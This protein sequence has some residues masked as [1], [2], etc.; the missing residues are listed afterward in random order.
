[1]IH[2]GSNLGKP[3]AARLKIHEWCTEYTCIFTC[4]LSRLLL[5]KGCYWLVLFEFFLDPLLIH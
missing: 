2:F 1:M 5:V 3:A 4:M